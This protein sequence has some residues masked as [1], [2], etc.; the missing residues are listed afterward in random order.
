[1][2]VTDLDGT[3]LDSASRLSSRNRV[4]LEALGAAGVVRVVATGRSGMVRG[5]PL[6]Q[7]FAEGDPDAAW[8]PPQPPSNHRKKRDSPGATTKRD[9]TL[10]CLHGCN[11]RVQLPCQVRRFLAYFTHRLQQRKGP[12]VPA[13]ALVVHVS[14]DD[15]P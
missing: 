4:A 6:N 15:D 8:K 10:A 2:L 7:A 9:R 14:A 1:M 3:L 12:S 11:Y 13:A 5:R